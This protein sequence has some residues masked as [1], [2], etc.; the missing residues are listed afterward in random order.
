[1]V[2]ESNKKYLN[3]NRGKKRAIVVGLIL[4]V[5]TILLTLNVGSIHYPF[6]TI[7]K[8]LLF[9]S[10][11]EDVH[12]IWSLR[13]VRILAAVLVGA[14]LSLSGTVMQTVLKNPLASPYTLGISSAAA[15]GASFA[16]IFLD[17]GS[18]TSSTIIIYNP[19]IVTLSAFV[20]SMGATF[21]VL[22]LAKLNRLK[23]ESLILGG[24]AIAAI[25]SA[26]LTFM[27]YVANSVQLANI[28]SWS[29][30]EL[31][32]ANKTLL[33]IVAPLFFILLVLFIFKRWHFNALYSSDD[34]ATS[35][36]IN[37]S[38]IRV[39][40]MVLSSLIASTVVSFFGIISFVGLLG[41]HIA[42][43]IV[44]DEHLYLFIFSSIVG[45]ILLLV[46]DSV[47]RLILLPLIL[48]VGVITSLLGAP[49]FISL[50]IGKRR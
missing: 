39:W 31:G 26:G 4:L 1:M 32:R 49:L 9:P 44:G 18:S 24:I 11:S 2:L 46:A 15:F 12:I 47:A 16:I 25:S 42:R 13:M 50:L 23:K 21:F 34:V 37:T 38:K 30:G 28:V 17:G 45:A 3:Q 36:G 43:K 35:L 8:T 19:Y 29:F 27:Q 5:V 20:F 41:P 10:S 7:I 22:V 48:P 33:L 6:I 40:A 14:S